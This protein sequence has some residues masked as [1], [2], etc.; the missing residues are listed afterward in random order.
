[1]WRGAHGATKGVDEFVR[2]SEVAME[3]INLWV[4]FYDLPK[5]MMKEQVARKLGES[6]GNVLRVDTTFPTYLRVRIVFSLAKLL[7]PEIKMKIKGRG[8]MPVIVRYENV[9]HFCFGYGRLGHADRECPDVNIGEDCLRFGVESRASPPKRSKQVMVCGALSMAARALNLAGDQRTRV[10]KGSRSDCASRVSKNVSEGEAKVQDGGV[11]DA[12]DDWFA[13]S[14]DAVTT[15]LAR[16][17]E[18]L[19]VRGFKWK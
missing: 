13:A 11:P 2:P 14:R 10:L 5:V 8:D 1:M 3:S 4:W 6:L 9:P 18:D 12:G 17:V 15:D 7:V 19:N 16:G